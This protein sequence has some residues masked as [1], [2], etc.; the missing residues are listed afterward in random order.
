MTIKST[1]TTLFMG[2]ISPC[3]HMVSNITVTVFI[4]D[5]NVEVLY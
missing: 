5:P 3:I 4:I 2:S 1:K